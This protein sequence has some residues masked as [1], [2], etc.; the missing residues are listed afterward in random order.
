MDDVIAIILG[1]GRGTRLFPLTQLRSK[2]AVPIGGSYRL[3]DVAVSNCLHA[4]MRRMFV[5]TQYQSESLNSHIAGTYKFDMFS[6]GF[7]RVLAAEQTEEHND[8]F[9]GTSD[10]VRQSMR[11]IG[12]RRQHWTDAVI[13]AGDQLYRMDFE[14]MLRV[15]RE[16]KAEATVAM[17]VVPAEQ[18]S[19]FGIMK[20]DE[21]GRVV[22][23]DEKPP[24]ARLP[25]LASKVAGRAGDAYLASMGIYIFTHDALAAALREEKHVDFGRHVIP[26]ML[27]RM[28]VQAYFYEG[29]WEDV[30]TIRSYYEANLAL[31]AAAPE[32]SFFDAVRPIYTE[33]RILAPT[34]ILDSRIRDALVADGCFLDRAEVERSVIG[35]RATVRAGATVRESLILGADYYEGPEAEAQAAREALPPLGV[36]EGAVIQGAIVDKNARIGRDVRI[37]NERREHEKNGDGYFIREGIVIVPKR[38]VIPDGTVI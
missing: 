36:G 29:Y 21:R 35:L 19:A 5:L 6:S 10:A 25:G 12:R 34:K 8:W 37:V 3:I 16:T 2:P 24:P 9:Q 17:K 18:A 31:T 15:H 7:V 14:D 23:F 4:N 26:A 22:H 28:R 32:F 38:A 33:P 1:G 13:L 20:V 11:H 30:G 27:G